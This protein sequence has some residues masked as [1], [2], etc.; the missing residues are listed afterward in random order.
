MTRTQIK[1]DYFDW[2]YEIVC[3]DRFSKNISY[4]KLF[5]YL[6]TIEFTWIIPRDSNRAEDG[7]DLRYRYAYFNPLI[8]DEDIDY[9]REYLGGPCSVLEMMVAIAIRCEEEIMDDPTIGDRTGQWV[10]RMINNLDLSAMS[11]DRFD[12]E[13]VWSAIQTFLNRDYAPDGTGGL[14]VVRHSDYDMRNIEIWTQLSY[15]IGEIT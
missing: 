7:I 9:V 14:F 8:S 6:H 15:F 1:K 3:G 10:W 4:R 13:Y 5:Q 11:D 2:M 12:E